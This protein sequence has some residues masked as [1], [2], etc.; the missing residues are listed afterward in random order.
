[1]RWALPIFLLLGCGD[2]TAP[3]PTP[4]AAPPVYSTCPEEPR[5]TPESLATKAVAYDA[6][7]IALH[8]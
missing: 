1:M 6:R 4:D 3:P 5:A 2:D 8:T 7:A